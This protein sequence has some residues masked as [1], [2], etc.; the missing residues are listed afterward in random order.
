MQAQ[1]ERFLA[2]L[3]T[4]PMLR[5][6]FVRDPLP[7]ARQHGLTP[8]ECHAFAAMP[9]RDLHTAA[10]SYAHK[11]SSKQRPASRWLGKLFRR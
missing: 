7:I 9:M 11:R 8:E 5:E 4:D 2:Q 10:R 1:L 3:L 6:R